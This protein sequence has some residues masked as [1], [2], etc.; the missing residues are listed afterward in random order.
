[1]KRCY[2]KQSEFPGYRKGSKPVPWQGST[3]AYLRE[4]LRGRNLVPCSYSLGER[5]VVV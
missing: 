2:R 5:V 3:E 4:Y 1:M